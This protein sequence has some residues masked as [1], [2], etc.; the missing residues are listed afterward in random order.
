MRLVLLLFFPL[1]LLAQVPSSYFQQEVNYRINVTLDDTK[2]SVQ[3][4][5]S[6]EYINHSPDTLR[7]IW[8]HL[9][10]NAFKNRHTAF[11]K[12]KL[13]DGNARFY[14]AREKDLGYY[15]GLDFKA[16]QTKINWKFDPKNPD[17]AVLALSAPLTPGG[18]VT[19]NT[20]FTLKIPASFSRLGHVETSYQM[21]QWYPKP[22]VYDNK[23][24]HAI[25]YLDMGEF[26]SEFG[27]FD[28][29]ITLPENYVVGATGVLQTPSEIEFLKQKEIESRQLLAKGVDKKKDPFPASA[30]RMK[31]IRYLADKVHDFAWFADKRFFVLK[32]TARLASGKTVDCWAMFTASQSDIWQK[33]AFYVKRA[34]EYYSD[35]VGEYPWP[36]ATAVHSALS[37]GGGME[38]PMITVIA[39][40]SSPADLDNVITHEV[41][42]NWFYG[43]LG[44]NEREHPFMDEGLNSYYEYRYM[45]EY[46][47]NYEPFSLPK[48]LFNPN[49]S[50]PVLE[51][52]YLFLAR[53]HQDT[54][55]DTHSNKFTPIAY[56]L[57]VY[58]KTAMV[59]S[60][61]EKSVGTARLDAAMQDYYRIW[62]F[63]HPYPDD[64]AAVLKKNG[65]PATWLME[66]LQTKKQADYAL[67]SVRKTSEGSWE[68]TIKRKGTLQSP[69]PVT[70]LKEGEDLSTTWIDAFVPEKQTS[71]NAPVT[72]QIA[73]DAPEADEFVIDQNHVTL[74]VNS[75]NN[76]RKTTGLFPGQRPLSLQ[77]MATFQNMYRNSIGLMPWVGWNNA[78]KTMLGMALYNPPF[79]PRKFQVFLLPGYAFGSRH[80]VGLAN[81]AYHF[82]P[83]GRIPKIT[84]STGLK[85]F[86]NDIQPEYAVQPRFYRIMPKIKAELSTNSISFHHNISVRT[87]FTGVETGVYDEFHNLTDKTWDRHIIHELAYEGEQFALPRPF[88][89]KIALETQ[90]YNDVYDQP[91]HYVRSTV[92]WLQQLYYQPKRKFTYRFFAGFFLNNSVRNSTVAPTAI[93]LNPQGFNDYKFDETFL[94]RGGGAGFLG[95][96]VGRNEGGFKGA[97]G[98][99]YA[100]VLGNS[101]IFA[102]SV[103]L[104]TDLPK[105]W[106]LGAPVKPYFDLGYFKDGTP[107]GEGRPASDEWLWN[108]GFELEFFKGGLEIYFPLFSSDNLKNLYCEQAGGR[109]TSGL[110]CGGN[111]FK[112]ISWSMRVNLSDP[113][114]TIQRLV[115]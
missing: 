57:E 37:A 66:S 79:P 33:G 63:K 104:K 22:A 75:R 77:P 51:N 110:F 31:T 113:L 14:F 21:T 80:F 76:F 38:Y 46:Y 49:K 45:Q 35:K 1:S 90:Q 56:G 73:V 95:R 59:M 112:T 100:A 39:N 27:S 109:K 101:N 94:A 36:H 86:D 88:H 103:N 55:P 64:F 6:F 23:G 74:D 2:H 16:G 60:W 32:D 106:T 54:P 8:V 15:S 114:S 115:Q 48:F 62:Q 29:T 83:G 24:W 28:V 47:G 78:G 68:L 82:Y 12:Q 52:A 72:R 50:G 81:L 105:K 40:S 13:R 10:G 65:L 18:R 26:Y 96:Q 69:F 41:G 67:K 97:F 61:F 108:G 98:A 58:M 89:Y 3:G 107:L 70:A 84:I 92:E 99:A 85:L 30:P 7:E 34:V 11:A 91:Q 71:Q 111:Y 44:S 5:I 87:L 93:S 19:I 42:H 9:W 43:V 25:P 4:D 17:I 20:P 102:A 53:E